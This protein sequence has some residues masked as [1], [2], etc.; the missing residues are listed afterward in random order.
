MS[1]P[2]HLENL[3][4]RVWCACQTCLYHDLF[5]CCKT[6]QGNTYICLPAPKHFQHS[7]WGAAQRKRES[8]EWRPIAFLV[9]RRSSNLAAKGVGRRILGVC[10]AQNLAA[11]V[12]PGEGL[13]VPL[14]GEVVQDAARHC[15]LCA[16]SPR[17]LGYHEEV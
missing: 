14:N 9:G 16:H 3:A 15:V 13:L 4:G 10:R 12:R 8:G 11:E 5:Y 1:I 6:S 17:C 2:K 7:V